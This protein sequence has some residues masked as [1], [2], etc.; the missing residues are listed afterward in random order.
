M[1][2]GVAFHPQFLKH[3]ESISHPECK[4]R[5]LSIQTHLEKS[6]FY[7]RLS[8][9]DTI[10][11]ENYSQEKLEKAILQNHNPVF[12]NEFLDRREFQKSGYF[13]AD[14]PYTPGSFSSALLAVSAGLVLAEKVHTGVLENAMA[15][16]RPPGHHSEEDHAMGFCIFNNVAITARHLKTL[17]YSRIL[18]LDFDVHHGNGTQNSFYDDDSVCFISLHQYPFYPGTGA[19]SETGLGKGK[20]FTHNFPLP[21]RSGIETYKPIFQNNFPK[22]LES[23]Q[24]EFILLSSGFDAHKEDPLGGMNLTTCDFEW[25]T[26]QCVEAS[27]NY[28]KGKLIS[29]LEGGYDLEALG[30]SVKVHLSV[31]NG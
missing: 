21:G 9:I 22:I 23:F 3:I 30:E 11:L 1:D 31:L 25:I 26:K 28:C 17:G 2:T 18:I 24:P 4:E 27:K 14:T 29:F 10:E 5:L 16:V 15:I 12:W 7:S 8:K 20:G 13:D 19:A 6:G